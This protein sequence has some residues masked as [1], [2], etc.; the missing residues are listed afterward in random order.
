MCIICEKIKK[1]EMTLKERNEILIE[2]LEF[3]YRACLGSPNFNVKKGKT[4]K[5]MCDMINDVLVKCKE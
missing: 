4:A 1:Q 5:D 3:V 2:T